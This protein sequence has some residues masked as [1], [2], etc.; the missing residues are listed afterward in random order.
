MSAPNS[1]FGSRRVYN[2][3]L[4]QRLGPPAG[5]DDYL[6]KAQMMDYEAIRAQHEAYAAR[7]SAERPATGSVYW[8]LNSAWP[9]LHWQLLDRYLHP[10]GAYFGVK[11]AAVRLEHAAYDYAGGSAWV[12]NRSIDRRG[13]RGI[14]A[15]LIGL[16]GGHLARQKMAVATEPNATARAGG[17]RNVA[18]LRLVLSDDA[19]GE[20]LC[21]SV[22][23]LAHD[24]DAL[25]WAN[26]TWWNTPV[27]QFADLTALGR[28]ETATVAVRPAPGDGGAEM[29]LE[30][31]SPV[32]AVFIRLELVDASGDYV[33]PVF[34]SDNYVTLWPRERLR[35]RVAHRRQGGRAKVKVSGVNVGL[36]EVAL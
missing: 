7:W 3:A 33:D 29:K 22:Y 4:F 21:R 1:P 24:V 2:A 13:P 20:E 23:W 14:A 11:A 27:S 25:D 32:P 12:I 26:S 9:S 35:L 6:L 5:F 16:D 31:Q 28:L 15:E 19:T 36:Q 30:N 34:W 18:L 8:M 17:I 10:A